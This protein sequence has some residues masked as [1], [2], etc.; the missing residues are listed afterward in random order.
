MGSRSTAFK[1]RVVVLTT[2]LVLVVLYAVGDVRRREGRTR[3][4][5][6][7]DVAVVVVSRTPVDPSLFA[8]LR[9]RIPALEA[10]LAEAGRAYRGDLGQPFAFHLYGPIVTATLP[11]KATGDGLA[12]L[13]KQT[14]AMRAYTREIDA[15]A[16]IDADTYDSRIYLTVTPRAAK[17]RAWVEGESEQG[18]RLGQ[19]TV[20]LD[21]TMLDVA[22]MV[23]THEAFHTLGATDKVDA[24]GR[25]QVPQGLAD[26]AQIP[27]YPQ[28][29]ADVMARGRLV[30]PGHEELPGTLDE[31]GVGPDTARE[32]HWVR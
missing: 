18:G 23:V 22:W 25:T 32:I 20:E 31:L 10:R 3:W 12:D 29:R 17:E 28:R 13:A 26:P 1:V 16:A 19:V 27:L 9:A 6:T 15:A 21:D 30:A 7:L 4:D 8:G 24:S 5:R 2:A 11:P 14:L